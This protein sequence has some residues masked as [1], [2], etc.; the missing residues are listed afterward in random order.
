MQE[1]MCITNACTL[2]GPYINIGLKTCYENCSPVHCRVD[3]KPRAVDKWPLSPWWMY[4]NLRACRITVNKTTTVHKLSEMAV[5]SIP[6]TQG[7]RKG[8][9]IHNRYPFQLN[10]MVCIEREKSMTRG[11]KCLVC[12]R[13]HVYS[14]KGG[15]GYSTII[16]GW[17][18]VMP[19]HMFT[20]CHYW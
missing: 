8:L 1:L 15:G 9:S 13:A 16:G 7:L 18:N 10:K 11:T 20:N 12:V 5:L 14:K 19:H 17:I 2:R 6:P 3:G 4:S